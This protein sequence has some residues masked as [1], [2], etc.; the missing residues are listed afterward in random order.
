MEV[1]AVMVVRS[2]SSAFIYNNIEERLT[3]LYLIEYH[4]YEKY[5]ISSRIET[6]RLWFGQ[7]IR[8]DF[9]LFINK[10]V[11]KSRVALPGI[12]A[13]PENERTET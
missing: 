11:A 1:F 10:H 8:S 4:V 7:E 2:E 6:D 13:D 9:Q 5:F 3:L 12:M